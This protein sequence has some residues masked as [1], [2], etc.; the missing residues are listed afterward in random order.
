MYQFSIGAV[1]QFTSGGDTSVQWPD[2]VS[3]W[4]RYADTYCAKVNDPEMVRRL[5]TKHLRAT[6]R[7]QDLAPVLKFLASENGRRWHAEEREATR[8]LSAEMA[9]IQFEIELVQAKIYRAD[10]ARVYN[11]FIA[12]KKAGVKKP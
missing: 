9:K 7:E 6:T 12:E 1:C 3:A 5:Y 8:H 11:A 2:L 4:T 10:L